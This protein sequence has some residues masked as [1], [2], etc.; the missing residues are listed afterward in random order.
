[1]QASRIYTKIA[2]A[3]AD[4]VRYIVN[5]GGTSSTKTYSALQFIFSIAS[6]SKKRLV[7]SVVSES[8]PHLK[9]GALR[10]FINILTNAG[11]YSDSMYNMSDRIFNIGN[12]VVEFFSI[13][14]IDKAKGARRD[15]LFV[16]EAYAIDYD[17]FDQLEF[18]T[19]RCVLIDYN[20]VADFW[21]HTEILKK[22]ADQTCHIHST[23]KDNPFLSDRIRAAIERHKDNDTWWRVY[24]LGLVGQRE[25]LIYPDFGIIEE[26]PTY[27]DSIVH[28]LDFGYT[29]DPTACVRIGINHGREELYL[30]ELIY[31]TGLKMS[32]ICRE[33]RLAGVGKDDDLIADSSD[34]RLI[35]EIFEEGFN[36]RA[37]VKKEIISEIDVVKRY[38]IFVTS[39]SV[40]LIK[41]LRNYMYKKSKDG[42]TLNV[43]EDEYNHALDAFRYG[44]VYKIRPR[45]ASA[46]LDMASF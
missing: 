6:K 4:G 7:I 14:T 8:I 33:L 19:D 15:I 37:A 13:D 2:M 18:R 24:G 1:M 42:K 25:G 39:R 31:K 34:P 26:I 45:M 36:I 43:P 41:E 35:D 9:K 23:Y 46:I 29:N 11:V 21:C 3:Y 12:S 44:A 27:A 16:N 22:R 30:D 20:P 32:D 38:K 40:N 28:G 10:D 5:E 17:I